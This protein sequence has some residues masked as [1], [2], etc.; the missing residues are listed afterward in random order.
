ML[1][2]QSDIRNLCPRKFGGFGGILLS[3]FYAP[4]N[5]GTAVLRMHGPQN[6]GHGNSKNKIAITY[7]LLLEICDVVCQNFV[8]S[9]HLAVG[10]L[11]LCTCLM[12]DF[13]CWL[14]LFKG[15]HKT[16]SRQSFAFLRKEIPVRLAN[17][18]N[19]INLQPS[20]LRQMPSVQQ[21]AG[22]LVLSTTCSVNFKIYY[23]AFLMGCIFSFYFR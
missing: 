4:K 16:D 5:S 18:M 1:R 11:E 10:K 9:L 23:A 19:E 22:W 14:L 13:K 2:E 15:K 21:V 12:H 20:I 7:N 8:G 6:W 17:I 3:R